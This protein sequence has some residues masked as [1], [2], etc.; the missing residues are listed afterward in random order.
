M[1]AKLENEYISKKNKYEKY[2]NRKDRNEILIEIKEDIKNKFT[3][4]DAEYITENAYE[5]CC[6]LKENIDI[7]E[8]S[9]YLFLK[10]EHIRN[11]LSDNENNDF[12]EGPDYLSLMTYIKYKYLKKIT[13]ND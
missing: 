8:I 2:F 9:K 7:Y 10:N 3:K 13:C 12:I 4:E 6:L 1:N 11:K 5:Y